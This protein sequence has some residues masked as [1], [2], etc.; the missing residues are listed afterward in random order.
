MQNMI[1]YFAKITKMQDILTGIKII[2]KRKNYIIR[3]SH[4]TLHVCYAD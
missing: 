1:S 3:N 4:Q 2:R